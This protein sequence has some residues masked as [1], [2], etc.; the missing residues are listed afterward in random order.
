MYLPSR[1][2]LLHGV[3]DSKVPSVQTA[4]MADVLLNKLEAEK[5]IVDMHNSDHQRAIIGECQGC[6]MSFS[7]FYSVGLTE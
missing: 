7:Y 4:L 5:V 2:F 6:I 1:W 3:K